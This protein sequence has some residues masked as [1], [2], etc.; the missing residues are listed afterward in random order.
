MV[1]IKALHTPITSTRKRLDQIVNICKS[2]V[3]Q[4]YNDSY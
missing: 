2:V 4:N 1:I 3:F